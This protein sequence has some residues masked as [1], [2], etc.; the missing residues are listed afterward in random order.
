MLR[1]FAGCAVLLGVVAA[2]TG[3]TSD[4][5][6]AVACTGNDVCVRGEC[7][8]AYDRNWTFTAKSI[9]VAATEPDGTAWDSSDGSPPD[10]Y[11]LIVV[12]NATV[13]RTRVQ[14]DSYTADWEQV[15]VPVLL[16]ANNTFQ[17]SAVDS[18]TFGDGDL[19]VMCPDAPL[20]LDID[21]LRSGEFVCSSAGSTLTIGL[22]P[23]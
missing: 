16:T 19:I 15:S 21:T 4:P 12:D 20:P 17:V 10:P 5:T 6:C 14:S 23:E 7:E 8:N 22:N 2:A 9:D 11:A 1:S 3:C 18:D 13:L